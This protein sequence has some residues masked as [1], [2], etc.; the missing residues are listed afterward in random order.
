[1]SPFISSWVVG[2]GWLLLLLYWL[3]LWSVGSC[4]W[5][6]CC[7]AE[8]VAVILEGLRSSCICWHCFVR[9]FGSVMNWFLQNFG[10]VCCI[11]VT[12]IVVWW[13]LLLSLLETDFSSS[14]L[15]VFENVTLKICSISQVND[16]TCLWSNPSPSSRGSGVVQLKKRAQG[17]SNW[18]WFILYQEWACSSV[19]NI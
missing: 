15:F 18:Y 19:T 6:W 9:N 17:N 3:W 8:V 13:L 2:L 5:C 16:L 14:N 12:V 7:D 11:C 10:S 4:R 1:M